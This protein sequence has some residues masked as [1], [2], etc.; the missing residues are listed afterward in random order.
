MADSLGMFKQQKYKE[1][2]LNDKNETSAGHLSPATTDGIANNA[3]A[4]LTF[5]HVPS[6]TDVFFKAFI[7]TFNES[8][9]CDWTPDTVFGRTDP[10]YTFKNT[11]RSITLSWKIPA[12]TISEAYENLGR[13]QKLSQF[14][15]PSYASLPDP[16]GNP[17]NISTLTQSPLVRLKVMNLV[18]KSKDSGDSRGTPADALFS[19]Y[20]SNNNPSE[21]LLGVIT[22]MSVNHNLENQDAGVIQVKTNTVLPKLIEVSIDFSVIH[23]SV[24]GWET[25]DFG[26]HTFKDP[27]FPYSAV[28]ESE[29]MNDVAP[30]SYDERI[31]SRQ[32][33][34]N[35]R[36]EAEQAR[37]NAIA[38]GYN[39]MFG[40]KKKARDERKLAKL[41]KKIASGEATDRDVKNSQYLESAL[42]GQ[43]AIE[44]ESAQNL[45]EFM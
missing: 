13:V 21:G 8:Y 44:D 39:G 7:T 45:S 38:R 34:E 23:E 28:L 5:F 4:V 9:N 29:F 6:E 42:N 19:Q 11:Q 14:L 32:A 15:Y 12:E 40:K 20:T 31:A 27:S 18:Q 30:G 43:N 3:E 17:T 2:R 22:S 33:F 16:N 10:I 37:Q 24:L 41:N 1:I 36:V 35:D 26:E 25:N